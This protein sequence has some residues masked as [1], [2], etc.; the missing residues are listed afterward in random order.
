MRVTQQRRRA[1]CTDDST[2]VWRM[3]QLARLPKLRAC[4]SAYH[5]PKTPW[6]EATL[7]TPLLLPPGAEDEEDQLVL[8]ASVAQHREHLRL[9][10]WRHASR[11]LRAPQMAFE[12][13]SG[14][15]RR[16]SRW[17]GGGISSSGSSSSN[18]RGSC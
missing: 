14:S 9:Q 12:R 5:D 2:C 16:L 18:S 1:H 15:V 3:L 10:R 13:S 11:H 6:C 8:V 7:A 4:V 17:R